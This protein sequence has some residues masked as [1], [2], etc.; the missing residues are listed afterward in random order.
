MEGAF[1]APAAYA[2]TWKP[3]GALLGDRDLL[4]VEGGEAGR[5][6]LLGDGGEAC[7]QAEGEGSGLS[8]FLLRG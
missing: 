6:G 1:G 4:L 5:R 3:G 2:V 7:G 8:H